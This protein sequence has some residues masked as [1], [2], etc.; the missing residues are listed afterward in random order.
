MSSLHPSKTATR[1]D[2]VRTRLSIPNIILERL[3]QP[4][5]IVTVAIIAFA[6][7]YQSLHP[8]SPFSTRRHPGMVLWDAIVTVT[9]ASLLYAVDDWLNP[10]MLSYARAAQ[11]PRPT[12]HGAKSET[13]QKLLGM[14]EPGGIMHSV[15]NA[16]RKGLMTLTNSS[17]RK[18][19]TY[20]PAGLG[21]SDNSCFQN[22]I[23]QG[24][25]SL[26]F[27]PDY[28][29]AAIP[30]SENEDAATKAEGSASTLLS[31]L[32]RLRDPENNGNT[33]WTPK[34]LKSLDTW[35][36]QDAQEYYSKLLDEIDKEVS[37]TTKASCKPA[38]LEPTG[39]RDDGES[40]QHSDDSGYQTSSTL[41]KTGSEGNASKNPLEGLVAQRVA[42]TQCGY[43]EGLSLIPFN[44]LTLNLGASTHGH[45]LYESL[46]AYTHLES[47]D[48]VQCAKCSLLKIQRLLD[49][50][51]KRG[52]ASGLSDKALA[53]PKSRL[54]AANLAL[55]DDNFDEKTL[56][57]E[58]KIQDQNRVHTTKTKQAAIAR[59]PRSLAIHVNRSVF[60]ERTGT[61]FKNFAGLQFPSTLDLGPW[62]LGSAGSE[63]ESANIAIPDDKEMSAKALSEEEQWILDPT[64][65][66][67]AGD[68]QTSK[69]AGPKY[70]LRAVITHQGHHNNGH[71]VCYRK[72]SQQPAKL[73]DAPSQGPESSDDEKTMLGEETD[74]DGDKWWRLSDDSV[75]E[76]T[77][78][79]VL[80]Q[81]GVFMLFYDCVDS[82]VV[83]TNQQA[84]YAEEGNIV[85]E[86]AEVYHELSDEVEPSHKE[87]AA[88]S[89]TGDTFVMSLLQRPNS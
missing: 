34:I 7:F 62:C 71:Y 2:D 72:D 25:A 4:T 76:V 69:I 23:V 33:L 17:L 45:D 80:G 13:L 27:F 60:D 53:E 77:Q 55:E 44:C 15:A 31:L 16:G 42:C 47:I 37:K 79:Q 3:Q 11:A 87:E 86:A 41:A 12:S 46:D 70:E 9:P 61:M 6:L 56:R 8:S 81:G 49:I 58:C 65:S 85:T 35:Q 51:I 82:S 14:N 74:G 26:E 89:T 50:L 24:L 63:D 10:P 39:T 1:L 73:D 38:G 40:S 57:D 68:Q 52:Q 66:M 21:N 32:T 18:G 78:K 75:W 64:K 43:S 88:Q 54:E 22:S 20:P 30:E 5:V 84:S 28:L 48:G 29:K 83:L 67:V 59:P 36:Q 19:H